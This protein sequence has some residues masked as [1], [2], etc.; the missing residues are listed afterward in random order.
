VTLARQLRG[1]GAGGQHIVDQH[2]VPIGDLGGHAERPADRQL[3]LG[4]RSF[5]QRS[6]VQYPHCGPRLDPQTQIAAGPAGDGLGLVEAAGTKAPGVHRYR[7]QQR[8]RG[9]RQGQ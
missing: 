4:T 1:R 6:G 9:V 7:D 8:R 5:G 2:H 3:A